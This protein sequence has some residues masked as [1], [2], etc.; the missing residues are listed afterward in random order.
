MREQIMITCKKL[1]KHLADPVIPG[2][3]S[4]IIAFGEIVK[5]II[6]ASKV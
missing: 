6:R 4:Q 2:I 1:R 5:D 3:D